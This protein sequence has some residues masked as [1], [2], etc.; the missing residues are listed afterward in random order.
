MLSGPASAANRRRR[1]GGSGH[2]RLLLA[3]SVFIQV[4]TAR[5]ASVTL[6]WNPS[7]SGG[8]RGY[9]VYIGTRS[10]F[11]T[12]VMDVGN[13]TA[14]T[15][16]SLTAGGVYYFAI[17]AYDAG[18]LES[19]FSNELSYT[20]VEVAVPVT[21]TLQ[22]SRATAG[23]L[24]LTVTGP[25]GRTYDLLASADLRS[26]AVIRVVSLSSSTRREASQAATRPARMENA[27]LMPAA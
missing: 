26:W 21:A 9:R 18:G 19:A 15:V 17:T 10:G 27:T 6:A 12:S 1:S 8:V 7:P 2:I 11:Y 16:S 4:L 23:G 22:L 3:F 20:P 25:A 13:G 24:V 5:A 14:V